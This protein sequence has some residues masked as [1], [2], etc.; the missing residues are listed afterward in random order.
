LSVSGMRTGDVSAQQDYVSALW[1]ANGWFKPVS[2]TATTFHVNLAEA[3][4]TARWKSGY[5]KGFAGYG[6]YGDED[7]AGDNTRNIYYYSV[8]A[9]QDL[10]HKFYAGTRFS[11]IKSAGGYPLVGYGNMNTYF[12]QLTT[13][14]WALSLGLGYRFSEQ[15][16]V[17]VEYS[18]TGG[19]TTSGQPRSNENY[20]ATQV[21]FKF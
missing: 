15:L 19:D 17:K 2:P 7:P 12:N 21:A 10:P 13:D 3:D 16:V 8:E 11:Q 20:F 4:V 6:R 18:M 1:F 9:V 14:L 5:V